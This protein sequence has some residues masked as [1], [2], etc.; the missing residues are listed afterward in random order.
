[1]TRENSARDEKLYVSWDAVTDA[2]GYNIACANSPGDDVPL[3]SWSW[4][5]C[6]SVTSGSTTSFTVDDD[7]RGGITRDLSYGRSYAVAVRAVTTTPAQASPWTVSDDAHP[8]RQI[9]GSDPISVSRANGSLT[10]SWIQPKFSTGY[11]IACATIENGVLSADQ[12][13]A[14]VE[15]ATIGSDRRVTATITSWTVDGT[16][17]TVDDS[18]T[19]S[20]VVLTTNA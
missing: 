20:L 8:A 13:C 15:T 18:K 2:Q 3:T 1:M 12:L 9:S 17:Y 16:S 14:D 11:K 19:Y 10:L 7:L 6:G 5:H 4:W